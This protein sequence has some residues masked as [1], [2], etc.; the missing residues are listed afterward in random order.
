MSIRGPNVTDCITRKADT[1]SSPKD[2]PE[3][4]SDRA[5]QGA[6]YPPGDGTIKKSIAFDYL[7]KF[8]FSRTLAAQM[9]MFFLALFFHTEGLPGH[10][11]KFRFARRL[12]EQLYSDLLRMN[13]GKKDVLELYNR[14]MSIKNAQD[15]LDCDIVHF[16]CFGYEAGDCH[17]PVVVFTQDD[18]HTTMNRISAFKG[19]MASA[20]T[21][22]DPAALA[23]FNRDTISHAGGILVPCS[24]DGGFQDYVRVSDIPAFMYSRLTRR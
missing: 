14:S 21:M 15:Y 23:S 16:L 12:W 11:G 7:F 18:L 24:K 17:F 3:D 2:S 20:K 9:H 10:V 22:T 5:R 4:F 1:N 19:T 6:G 8:Q 13:P